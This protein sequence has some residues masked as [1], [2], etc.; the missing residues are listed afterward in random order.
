MLADKTIL[1]RN[2]NQKIEEAL[3]NPESKNIQDERISLEQSQDTEFSN[4]DIKSVLKLKYEQSKLRKGLDELE[5]LKDKLIE[6]NEV[7]K[8]KIRQYKAYI[9]K[10]VKAL[11]DTE[12]NLELRE[13]AL[14][15]GIQEL[16]NREHQS[17]IKIKVL[18][19]KII[20]KKK[21]IQE[22]QVIIDEKAPEYYKLF[23]KMSAKSEM[24]MNYNYNMARADA[25]HNL[26]YRIDAIYRGLY[27]MLFG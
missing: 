10:Q 11:K 1:P 23:R 15:Q 22:L 5:E 21:E 25:W 24:R 17:E 7:E 14:N 6:G 9:E 20:T 26:W 19:E 27:Q 3:L 18:E 12:S 8:D 2:K 4:H 13:E 16:E